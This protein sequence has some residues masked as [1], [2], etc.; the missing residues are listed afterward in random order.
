MH[1]YILSYLHI[2]LFF[3]LRLSASW[4]LPFYVHLKF[5]ESYTYKELTNTYT[6]SYKYMSLPACKTL[7]FLFDKLVKRNGF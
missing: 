6:A 5:L 3:T 1:T 2:Q 7:N 4:L